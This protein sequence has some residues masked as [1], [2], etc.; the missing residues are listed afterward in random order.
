[1][2][3]R[4]FTLCLMIL[5]GAALL[6]W[7][8]SSPHLP[9]QTLP[10][11][12]PQCSSIDFP[13]PVDVAFDHTGAIYVADTAH[14]QI[15]KYAP[16]SS[17][18]AETVVVDGLNAPTGIAIDGDGNLYIADS[19]NHRVLKETMVAGT[20]SQSL[21]ADGLNDPT[22]VA[23]DEAGAVYIADSTTDLILKEAPTL[24]GYTPSLVTAL[25]SP[26]AT[27]SSRAPYIADTSNR[28]QSQ[29]HSVRLTTTS[30]TVTLSSSTNPVL[31][32]NPIMLVATLASS[33]GTPTG[34]VNFFDGSLLLGSA[35]LSPTGTAALTTSSLAIGSHPIT[36]AYGGDA[37]FNGAT[38]TPLSEVVQDFI[39]TTPVMLDNNSCQC[40]LPLGTTIF[41]FSVNPTGG[42]T[43]PAT[44]NLAVAAVPSGITTAFAPTSVAAG[45]GPTPISLTIQTP[46][47]TGQLR[48]LNSHPLWS[49]TLS[50]LILPFAGTR[51]SKALPGRLSHRT[52]LALSL[53]LL[54]TS[55]SAIN[56]CSGAATT[57]STRPT[58]PIF[59][60]TITATS[61]ALQHTTTVTVSA[62]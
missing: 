13:S 22:A 24:N 28:P 29:P 52:K 39:L 62:P 42:A 1:M 16:T 15:L 12:S 47:G 25:S 51:R 27:D 3:S 56:G 58:G 18:Y 2:R 50:L 31:V 19:G 32:S 36:A 49:I 6:A 4:S 33:G 44:V 60:L 8:G 14:N 40:H 10:C 5:A 45:S 46:T 11:V 55:A 35:S 53:L 30:P 48:P 7:A 37:A 20:Y 21:V 57:V 17:G 59:T 43:L 54:I 34:S 41:T 38:S 61:G 9:A 23:V 26:T